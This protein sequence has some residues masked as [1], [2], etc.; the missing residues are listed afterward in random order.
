MAK[1]ISQNNDSV[2]NSKLKEMNITLRSLLTNHQVIALTCMYTYMRNVRMCFCV[3][4]IILIITPSCISY[5]GQK[6]F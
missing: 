1:E 3:L 5:V 6:V 4:Y 2:K